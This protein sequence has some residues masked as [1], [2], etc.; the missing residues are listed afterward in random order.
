MKKSKDKGVPQL[1]VIGKIDHK[2]IA[3]CEMTKLRVLGLIRKAAADTSSPLHHLARMS[4]DTTEEVAGT[5][6]MF[7]LAKRTKGS[8]EEGEKA[9]RNRWFTDGKHKDKKRFELALTLGKM[10]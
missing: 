8:D 3:E 5:A 4:S 2:L 1:P 9:A 6:V 7:W 10:L